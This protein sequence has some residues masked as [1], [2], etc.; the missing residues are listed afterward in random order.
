MANKATP[1]TA[2][3]GILF[4]PQ[5]HLCLTLSVQPFFGDGVVGVAAIV[6]MNV[7]N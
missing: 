2:K 3:N 4:L 1:V 7:L 5:T 6:S